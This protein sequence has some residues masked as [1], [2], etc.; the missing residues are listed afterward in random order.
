ME[1]FGVSLVRPLAVGEVEVVL[2]AMVET[3][4]E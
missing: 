1:A 3:R 4:S 2:A